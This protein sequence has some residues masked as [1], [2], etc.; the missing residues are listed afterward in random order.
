MKIELPYNFNFDGK[1]FSLLDSYKD[2]F[3]QIDCV[4]MPSFIGEGAINTR[5]DL[6]RYP[7]TEEEYHEHIKEFQKRG[8]QI[9]ILMQRNCSMELIDKYYTKFG[10]KDF[11]INDN[12]LAREIKEKYPDMTLRL[13]ITAKA[14]VD[15]INSKELDPYDTIVLFFWYNRHLD[16]IKKLPKK[17]KYTVLVNTTCMY[18]CPYCEKHWFGEIWVTA[19]CIG[20]RFTFCHALNFKNTA[21]IRPC[22]THYF[23]NYVSSFKLE[24]REVESV[25]IFREFDKYVNRKPIMRPFYDFNQNDILS[26]YNI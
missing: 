2:K 26:N 19:K 15:E 3:Q 10:I 20:E 21:Y 9:T 14:T 1:Y 7:K 18:N 8:I 5:I 25:S 17:H 22:D 13:S 16:T 24:G 6:V 4:Y 11:T 12:P 23:E